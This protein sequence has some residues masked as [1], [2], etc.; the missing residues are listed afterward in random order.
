MGDADGGRA[1]VCPAGQR[2]GQL[3]GTA[4]TADVY[5]PSPYESTTL[6]VSVKFVTAAPAQAVHSLHVPYNS[7]R[8]CTAVLLPCT[9]K[10]VLQQ[11]WT[12]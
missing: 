8:A 2:D 10:A 12:T 11:A 3:V 4:V 9:A 6:T 7:C 1:R 5:R